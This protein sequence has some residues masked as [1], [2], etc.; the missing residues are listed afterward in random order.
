MQIGNSGNRTFV[1]DLLEIKLKHKFVE[2]KKRTLN[3][4]SSTLYICMLQ[5]VET[6]LSKTYN[7]I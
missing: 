4:Q 7:Q 3:F 6:S 2:I 5:Y 1:I